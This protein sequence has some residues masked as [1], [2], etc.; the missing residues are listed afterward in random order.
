MNYNTKKKKIIDD[1]DSSNSRSKS[2]SDSQENYY[3]FDL[4]QMLDSELISNTESKSSAK[5]NIVSKMNNYDKNNHSS[6]SFNTS[7]L[8]ELMKNSS[9]GLSASNYSISIGSKKKN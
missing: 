2:S 6:N 9:F 1:S 3:K 5:I 7:E 4:D 8:E